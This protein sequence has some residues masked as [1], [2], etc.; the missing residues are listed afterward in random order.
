MRS[1]GVAWC[2]WQV[3][4]GREMSAAANALVEIYYEHTTA[5]PPTMTGSP[6][7]RSGDVD[8]PP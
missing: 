3:R 8:E 7:E 2:V 4:C 1:R 5:S 6:S